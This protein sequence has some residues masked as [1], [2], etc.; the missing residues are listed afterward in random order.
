[1]ASCAPHMVSLHGDQPY[2][3][4]KLRYILFGQN[5]TKHPWQCSINI[6]RYVKEYAHLFIYMCVCENVNEWSKYKSLHT[7]IIRN[8]K[9]ICFCNCWYLHMAFKAAT[10]TRPWLCERDRWHTFTSC[11]P[12]GFNLYSMIF[13]NNSNVGNVS[14]CICVL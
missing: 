13:P 5:P 11:L 2:I 10:R 3:W 6:I 14:C 4:G 1:M 8:A 12:T 7:L 9:I